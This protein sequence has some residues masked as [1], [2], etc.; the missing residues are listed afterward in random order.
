MCDK[1]FSGEN[2]PHS[3]LTQSIIAA[4]IEVHKELGPGFLESIYEKA[5]IIALQQQGHN[6]QSQ[7]TL[8]VLFRGEWVGQHRM[9][10]LVDDA[11]VVE[12]KSVQALASVHTA[13]L[14]ST[15]KAAQKAIGLLINFNQ[16][17]LAHGVKRVKI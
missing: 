12:L 6:V 5:L 17:I 9:D 11:V 7:V 16:T 13:Q 2:Y 15:L 1:T 3:Q 10:L 4:A 14:R 8:N